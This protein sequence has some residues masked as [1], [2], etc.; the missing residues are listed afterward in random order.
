V[1]VLVLIGVRVS[2]RLGVLISA[3]PL[4]TGPAITTFACTTVQQ[5]IRLLLCTMVVQ[6]ARSSDYRLYYVRSLMLHNRDGMLFLCFAIYVI[7]GHQPLD[8]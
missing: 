1:E 2:D 5:V 8:Y 3:W 7:A 4:G 6:L